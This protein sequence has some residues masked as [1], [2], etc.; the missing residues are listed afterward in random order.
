MAAALGLGAP[1]A[2]LFPSGD[3]ASTVMDTRVLRRLTARE[4]ATRLC[5]W[6]NAGSSGSLGR[7]PYSLQRFHIREPPSVS[8]RVS[9]LIPRGCG[10]EVGGHRRW[11]GLAHIGVLEAV[12]RAPPWAAHPRSRTRLPWCE[13]SCQGTLLTTLTLSVT[14]GLASACPTLLDSWASGPWPGSLPTSPPSFPALLPVAQLRLT[15][16]DRRLP[17]QPVRGTGASL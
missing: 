10:Q 8:G 9:G 5:L 2:L 11:P 6:P 3:Q 15:L 4:A 1:G 12:L 14:P 7:A 17:S 16:R 13:E